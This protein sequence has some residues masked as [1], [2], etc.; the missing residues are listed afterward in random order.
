LSTSKIYRFLQ[1]LELGFTL[2]NILQKQGETFWLLGPSLS[3]FLQ[4]LLVT[5]QSAWVSLQCF[6]GRQQKSV[7]LRNIGLFQ[8]LSQYIAQGDRL[9]CLASCVVIIPSNI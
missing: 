9:S 6:A 1:T 4:L 3:A 7:G 2:Y 5:V 8:C